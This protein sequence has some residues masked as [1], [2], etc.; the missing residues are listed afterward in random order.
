MW[1]LKSNTNECKYQ[2][3]TEHRYRKQTYGYQRGGRE[4]EQIRERN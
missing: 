3:E 4:E 2:T 1:N